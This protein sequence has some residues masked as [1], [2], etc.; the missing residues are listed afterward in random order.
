LFQV[1]VNQSASLIGGGVK[2]MYTSISGAEGTITY[3]SSSI[4]D[5]IIGV[6]GQCSV[7]I[8]LHSASGSAGYATTGSVLVI[9]DEFTGERMSIDNVPASIVLSGTD[10]ETIDGEPY[11]EM[12]GTMT[13]LSVYSNGYNW[14]VF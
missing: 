9:K 2:Y 6:K 13:A 4:K 3:A 5:H 1:D 7:E 10:G 11:Y 8:R 12:T 14:F